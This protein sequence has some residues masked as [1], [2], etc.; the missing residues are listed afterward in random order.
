MRIK[1]NYKVRQIAGENL[2]VNQGKDHSDM[3]KVI[4]LNTTALL[5]WEA[6]QGKDFTADDA[7][8]VLVGRF[9][10]SKE[11]AQTDAG[12]WIES[13]TRCGVIA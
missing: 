3:T 1:E 13:L 10:I 7:A 5:L 2:V 8:E 11:Q 4:S 12:R 6:L 9:G